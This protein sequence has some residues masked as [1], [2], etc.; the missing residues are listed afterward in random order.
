MVRSQRSLTEGSISRGLVQFALPILYANVLQSLN[1]SVNSVW[2]G[3]YLGEAA[4][5]A[6]ANANVVMF[7][8]I[9]LAFGVAMAAT[10]LVGQRI[11][12]NDIPGAKQAVGTSATFFAGVS[13]GMAIAGLTLSPAILA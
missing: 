6:T 4:L 8:L 7:L 2:V 10:I 3:R 1:T 13:V 5:T 9:G 12:A 11:G